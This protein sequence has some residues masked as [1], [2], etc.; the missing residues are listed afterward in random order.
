MLLR[1]VQAS[2]RIEELTRDQPSNDA[3]DER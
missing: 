3:A 1:R 2:M